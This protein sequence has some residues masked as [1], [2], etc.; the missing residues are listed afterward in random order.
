MKLFL[1][2]LVI[3]TVTSSLAADESTFPNLN[4]NAV[5]KQV[6]TSAES[7]YCNNPNGEPCLKCLECTSGKPNGWK[8]SSD[9]LKEADR[10]KTQYQTYQYLC[11]SYIVTYMYVLVVGFFHLVLNF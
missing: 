10:D 2:V 5:C 11:N 8:K 1:A 6:A 7:S 9:F 4:Q 3:F